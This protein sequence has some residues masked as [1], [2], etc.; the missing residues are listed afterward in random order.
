M[1]NTTLSYSV[2]IIMH[3]STKFNRFFFKVEKMPVNQRFG[4]ADPFNFGL[5]DPDMDKDTDRG[6]KKSVKIMENSHN[7][8]QNHKNIEYF[9]KEITFNG[10]K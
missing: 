5:P 1:V 7:Y 4:A 8:L 10:H 2:T 9:K 6:S 3:L